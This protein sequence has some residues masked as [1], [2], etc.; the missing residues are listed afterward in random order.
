MKKIVFVTLTLGSA[1]AERVSSLLIDYWAKNGYEVT[2]VQTEGDNTTAN[3][4]IDSKVNY[5]FVHS[6]CRF[7]P[8]KRL[9]DAFN[10][11]K[12]LKEYPNAVAIAFIR[13]S[14]LTLG[15]A[16]FFTRS[17]Y[18][19]SE[20]NDPRSVPNG[21]IAKKVRNYIFSRADACV[22]QTDEA[23]SYFPRKV[24]KK[25]YVIPNPIN[26][27]LPDINRGARRKRVIAVCRL[28]PQKN[29]EMLVNAY[30]SIAPDFPDYTLEIYGKGPAEDKLRAQ[31]KA[32]NMNDKIIL[33][34]F[35]DD[36]FKE[37][38]DA[39]VYVSSSNYEGI[40]NSMLEALAMG[41]TCIVTDCPAGGARMVIESGINGILVPVNDEK[42]MSEAI[43]SVLSDEK[44]AAEMAKEAEKI[45]HAFSINQIGDAWIEVFDHVSSQRIQ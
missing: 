6:K 24:Q 23:K 39:V 35:S 29:L 31:I 45:R 27:N 5:R 41:M 1:G 14:I 18:I 9:E 4:P 42:R 11:A 36:V 20:R 17:R 25:G 16:A 21:K 15:L 8:I 12:I 34:G 38:N 3:Y 10:V 43:A 44:M 19:V 30:A 33:R 40:S 37:M 7:M 22:F 26:N 2:V 32:L 13:R 28:S